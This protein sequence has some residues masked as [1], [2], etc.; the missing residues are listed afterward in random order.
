MGGNN[1]SWDKHL[2]NDNCFFCDVPGDIELKSR[3]ALWEYVVCVSEWVSGDGIVK[4]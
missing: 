4:V 3:Y 2:P 1:Q